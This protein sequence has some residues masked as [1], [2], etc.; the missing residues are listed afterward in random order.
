MAAMGG[1]A[2]SV[3]VAASGTVAVALPCIAAV[4]S[5]AGSVVVR[6]TGVDASELAAFAFVGV[7]LEIRAGRSLWLEQAASAA[8]VTTP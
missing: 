2:A 6:G 5:R 1:V 3:L 8:A 7:A 4:A